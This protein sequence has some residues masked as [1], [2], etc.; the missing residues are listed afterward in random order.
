MDSSC[1]REMNGAN[2]VLT[3]SLGCPS[4]PSSAHGKGC[5]LSQH[6]RL[7]PQHRIVLNNIT[8]SAGS[9]SSWCG[10]ASLLRPSVST[11]C[12]P[13]RPFKKK[14]AL[15]HFKKMD[16]HCVRGDNTSGGQ[17]LKQWLMIRTNL[18]RAVVHVIM[19]LCTC[20]HSNCLLVT[21]GTVLLGK[22]SSLI[23]GDRSFGAIWQWVAE[24][25]SDTIL[26]CIAR[27]D[28][29]FPFFTMCK[30]LVGCQELFHTNKCILLLLT[31]DPGFILGQQAI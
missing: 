13:C 27:K 7:R 1:C 15:V 31:P 24:H 21:L 12:R 6:R 10:S 23:K 5:D 14:C 11:S 19:E 30:D 8:T 22:S 28:H 2:S 9:G 26:R 25:G 4:T 16:Q 17:E 18:K 29:L 3:R 20:H